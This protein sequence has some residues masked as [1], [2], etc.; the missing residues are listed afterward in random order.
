MSG[1]AFEVCLVYLDDIIVFS[2]TIDEH[3]R[4]QS[5]VLTRLRDTGLKL[6]PSK[7]RLLQKHV[8]FLG[9]F[10]KGWSEYRPRETMCNHGLADP[11]ESPGSPFV[12]RPLILLSSFCGGLC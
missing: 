4:L 3:F 10:V 12:H 7:C 9:H 8:A 11:S 5:A 1:L 6:N 2:S